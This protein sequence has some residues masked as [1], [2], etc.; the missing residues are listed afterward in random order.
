MAG[1]SPLVP[2]LAFLA[3]IVLCVVALALGLLQVPGK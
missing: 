1:T 2:V 3:P